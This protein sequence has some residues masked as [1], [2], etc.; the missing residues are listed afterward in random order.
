MRD[1]PR[2]NELAKELRLMIKNGRNEEAIE[3]I[4]QVGVDRT[5]YD[6]GTPL[7]VACLFEN[8]DIAKYCIENGADVNARNIE[9]GTALIDACK[10]GNLE[11]VKILLKNGAEINIRNKYARTPIAW[12]I[13][14]QPDQLELIEYLL[15]KGA[16]PLIYE[17]YMEDDQRITTRTA[18][19]FAKKELE[20]EELVALLD[21]YVK[22]Q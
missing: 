13:S 4:T 1:M 10:F 15:Q 9:G 18:Y 17:D 19:D 21:K 6:I 22:K 5:V 16:D 14:D 11:V 20:D 8:W 2:L 12:A 3:I 7:C